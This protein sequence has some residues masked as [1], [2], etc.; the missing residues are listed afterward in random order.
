MVAANVLLDE[1]KALESETLITKTVDIFNYLM[2]C[3]DNSY[4]LSSEL[5][6]LYAFINGE[7]LKAKVKKD[8]SYIEGVLPIVRELRDTWE[9]AEKLARIN[10]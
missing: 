3:L 7:L 2:V 8:K 6:T 9:E 5:M 4:E 1:N 10:K